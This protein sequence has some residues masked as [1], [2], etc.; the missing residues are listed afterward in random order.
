MLLPYLISTR[1]DWRNC[2]LRVFALANNREGLEL[3]QRNMASLLAKFRIEYSDLQI[4]PDIT[5]PASEKTKALF[6]S[7][8]ADFRSQNSETAAT[9]KDTS[10]SYYYSVLRQSQCTYIFSNN[11]GLGADGNKR[12]KQQTNAASRTAARALAR[13]RISG[14]DAA[15]TQEKRYISRNLSGMVRIVNERHAPSS[16]R[17]R[18]PN[19]SINILFLSI[20]NTV[21]ICTECY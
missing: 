7:L 17:P 20:K 13:R 10:E 8:I 14:G 6:E 11:Y 16:A 4:M 19:F 15:Y 18:Q 9:K 2:K 12:K 1:T 5:K 21:F 3:E